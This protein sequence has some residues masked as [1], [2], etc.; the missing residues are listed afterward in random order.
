M[1]PDYVLD[2]YRPGCAASIVA[3]HMDYY[4]KEWGFGRPF[5]AMV[6]HELGA[7]LARYDPEQDLF[8]NAFRADGALLASITIDGAGGDRA[9][10]RWFIVSNAARGAGLGR[11]L[12]DRAMAFCRERQFASVYLTTFEGL[13]AARALYERAG[14]QLTDE[15]EKDPWSGTVGIQRFELDLGADAPTV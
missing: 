4:A 10:L 2:E 6:A 5:E 8:L 14:F 1:P 7:F 13:H 9:Q 15:T 11:T 3:L 12:M